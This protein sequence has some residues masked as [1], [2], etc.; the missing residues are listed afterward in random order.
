MEVLYL[1][2]SVTYVIGTM[3]V[4]LKNLKPS[5]FCS[6]TIFETASSR[7]NIITFDFALHYRVDIS[8]FPLVE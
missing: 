6:S 1:F 4:E 2:T 8:Y 5:L 3:D 7:K